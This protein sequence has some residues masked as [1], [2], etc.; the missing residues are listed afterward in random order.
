[1]IEFLH[2][3]GSRTQRISLVF[4]VLEPVRFATDCHR[5]RPRGSIKTPS[6]VANSGYLGG[7]ERA[8]NFEAP[9]I[10]Y[11]YG[12]NFAGNWAMMPLLSMSAIV[13]ACACT[14]S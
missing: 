7:T 10:R 5:L 1:M 11:V 9:A 6:V 14:L 8:P 2:P 12:R 13:S 4:A 3:T